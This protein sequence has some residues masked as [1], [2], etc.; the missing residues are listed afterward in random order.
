MSVEADLIHRFARR[1]E[2][3]ARRAGLQVRGLVRIDPGQAAVVGALAGDG[4]LVVVEGAAGAGKTTAL[5]SAQALL[6]RQGHRLLVVTPTLK[7]A[8]VAAAETGAE[9]HSAAWLIHQ[10]GWRWDDDGHWAR[11]PDQRRVGGEHG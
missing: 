8:E 9:G 3:P 6:A 4:A 7:A 10:H 2:Q 11:R 5:R 1:S